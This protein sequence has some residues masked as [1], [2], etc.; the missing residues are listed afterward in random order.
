METP[1]RPR[2][3]L[4]FERIGK[5]TVWGGRSLARDLRW[6]PPFDGPLG[7]TWELSDVEGMATVVR[8]GAWAG[9]SLRQLME[10]HG[11][12]L[13]GRSKPGP[14]GRF[15]LL[16]KFLEAAQD[17]SVQVH[18]SDATAGVGR[19]GK[20]ECWTFL[21]GSLDGAEVWCG[22][23]EGSGADAFRAAA[24]TAEVVPLLRRHPARRGEFFFVPPGQP[25]AIR[26]GVRL[27]EIQ[28]TCDT[29]YRLYDWDRK[30]LDGQPR[31]LHLEQGLAVLDDASPCPGPFAPD[32]RATEDG[33]EAALLVHC[34]A[35]LAR[36]LRLPVAHLFRPRSYAHVMAVV[37]GSGQLV[38]PAGASARRDLRFGDVFLVPADVGPIRLEPDDEGLELI[39]ATAL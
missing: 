22:F 14:G 28:Q 5:Q 19:S 16:V 34:E 3:P 13:L 2:E 39:E 24:G 36:A 25:H 20:T 15:P 31:E 9:T 4:F 38:D 35:F 7:E 8:G 17:L 37:R 32:Y 27:L 18:P 29:T 6:T 26:A 12:H 1:S 33:C 30:G 23:A 21:D 11:R 10:R